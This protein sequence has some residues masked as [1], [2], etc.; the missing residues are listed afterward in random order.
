MDRI[1]SPADMTLAYGLVGVSRNNEVIDQ[2]QIEE[3]TIAFLSVLLEKEKYAYALPSDYLL[4]IQRSSVTADVDPVSEVWRRKLCEWCYEVV[5]HFGFDREVVSVALNYLDRFVS[6]RAKEA[7]SSITR[8]EFQLFAVTS[9]YMAIKVH[10]ET[11]SLEGPRQKLRIDAFVQLSRGF[12]QIS[13]IEEQERAILKAL[14]WN[15]NP[16]TSLKFIASFLRLCPKWQ[17]YNRSHCQGNVLG[18][19]YD[20]AR[21]LTELAVCVSHFSFHVKTSVIGYSA[22]LCAIEALQNTM[23]L[24]HSVKISFLNNIAEATNL[25]PG[26]SDVVRT[27]SL[28]KELCPSL[29]YGE[30]FPS[31]FFSERSLG[32]VV[33]DSSKGGKSSPVCVASNHHR[34]EVEDATVRKRSRSVSNS[35]QA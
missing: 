33:E 28:L 5:D 14:A 23:P 13:V 1:P 27:C 22:I 9:L 3:E 35:V 4:T 34:I 19:V 7:G 8:R 10:G 24:P 2:M 20:V 15:V 6:S 30:E 25:V 11:E 21:Y 31:D 26:D 32:I 17:S 12:F 29:F 16:P 18:G